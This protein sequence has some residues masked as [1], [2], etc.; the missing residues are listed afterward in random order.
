M[1]CFHKDH[2]IQQ[3]RRRYHRADV[4]EGSRRVVVTGVELSSPTASRIGSE[5]YDVYSEQRHHDYLSKTHMEG[6]D[7]FSLQSERKKLKWN[8]EWKDAS[9]FADHDVPR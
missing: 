8:W 7:C 3:A 5:P 6:R 9:A 4:V 2:G 1:V